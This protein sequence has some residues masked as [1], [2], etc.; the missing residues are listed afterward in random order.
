MLC[1][2][3][4]AGL[5]RLWLACTA[6]YAIVSPATCVVRP[7]VGAA[8]VAPIRVVSLVV[9]LRGIVD[10]YRATHHA[11]PARVRPLKQ[12]LAIK[13]LVIV[14]A[15]QS[16]VQLALPHDEHHGR[17]FARATV[18]EMLVFAALFAAQFGPS[19]TR[20]AL[21]DGAPLMDVA[22]RSG[23]SENVRSGPVGSADVGVSVELARVVG[24]NKSGT[25][26]VRTN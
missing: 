11:Y 7:L 5:L 15:L 17:L 18:L 26:P 14:C 22:K 10:T 24:D 6:Q 3:S 12:F 16:V 25:S 8:V 21:G 9:M 23:E 2:A 4:G 20:W 1:K 19:A 13:A